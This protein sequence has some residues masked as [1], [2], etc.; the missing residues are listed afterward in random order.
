[1]SHFSVV[2]Q[3]V[4]LCLFFRYNQYVSEDSTHSVSVDKNGNSP[5]NDSSLGCILCSFQFTM[6]K[7]QHHC[8]LC[9]ASCC[10]DCSKKRVVIDGAQVSRQYQL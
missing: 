2:L 10:D 9:N 1:M 3:S 5:R 7:R 8:R 6:F 4:L